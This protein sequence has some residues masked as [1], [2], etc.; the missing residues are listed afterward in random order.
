MPRG[1]KHVESGET[2]EET[3][4]RELKEEL[5]LDAAECHPKLLG[6]LTPHEHNVNAFMKV[7]EIQMDQAPPF[8]PNDFTEYYWLA[9]AAVLRR[10]TKGDCAKDDLPK[11]IRFFYL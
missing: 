10:I 1:Q 2:Y 4:I 7:W 9:P 3:F 5:N 8:N 11:L 6:Y